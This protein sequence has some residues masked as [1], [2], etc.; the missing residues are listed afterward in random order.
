MFAW[1]SS[2]LSHVRQG[3]VVDRMAPHGAIV[4]QATYALADDARYQP[5]LTTEHPPSFSIKDLTYNWPNPSG[6]EE[7]MAEAES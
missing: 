2:S 4:S 6:E 3:G 7:S 1:I 5:S